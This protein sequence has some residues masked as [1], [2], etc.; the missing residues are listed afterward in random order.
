MDCEANSVNNFYNK[1]KI[2]TRSPNAALNSYYKLFKL[3][4]IPS[5]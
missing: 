5:K 3:F 4:H 1:I 2:S